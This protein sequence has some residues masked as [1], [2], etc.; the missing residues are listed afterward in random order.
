MPDTVDA[1]GADLE[2]REGPDKVCGI[3]RYAAEYTPPGCAYAWP[4]AAT[5]ARGEVTAVEDRAA[6]AVPG[7]LAVLTHR[8]APR[9]AEP[10]DATLAVLQNEVAQIKQDYISNAQK[11]APGGVSTL[12]EDGLVPMEQILFRFL[13]D[14]V[15]LQEG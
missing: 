10:D 7:V 6:L 15:F 1:L 13:M 3:A 4:V 5:V 8:N 2:R 9:L 12:D 11:A 14:M